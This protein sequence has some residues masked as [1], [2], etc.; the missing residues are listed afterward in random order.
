MCA[1]LLSQTIFGS[2]RRF[3]GQAKKVAS[4]RSFFEALSKAAS[5]PAPGASTPPDNAG[6]ARG[7]SESVDGPR[8]RVESGSGAESGQPTSNQPHTADLPSVVAESSTAKTQHAACRVELPVLAAARVL[9]GRSQ[10]RPR[11]PREMRASGRA[12]AAWG[13]PGLPDPLV[14]RCLGSALLVMLGYSP[15]TYTARSISR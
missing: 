15:A 5:S 3:S 12:R 8:G 6:A 14:A 10:S 4:G 11:P 13:L 9:A 7:R 2:R 1:P